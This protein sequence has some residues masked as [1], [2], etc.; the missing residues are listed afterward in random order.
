MDSNDS[1]KKYRREIYKIFKGKKD[2]ENGRPGIRWAF[3]P[4]K[5]ETKYLVLG[6]NPSNSYRKVNLVIGKSNHKWF[7]DK[8]KTQKEYDYFL[9]NEEKESEITLLQELSHEHHPHFKKHRDFAK[10]LKLN[11]TDY[12]FFDLFPIWRTKQKDIFDDLQDYEKEK[13]IKAFKELVNR[14]PNLEGLLFFNAGAANF[15]MKENKI[16]WNTKEKVNVRK[17]HSGTRNSIIRIGN[18]DLINK[19]INVYGF[20]I[21]GYFGPK[22]IERL[23]EKSKQL[24]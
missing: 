8:F 6:I 19:S 7:K 13:S 21:G 15:F 22:E 3:E 12:Q 24:F 5:K 11:D 1:I 2:P 16:K 17:D 14:H 10:A 20:G 4:I 23:A 18:I 9:S